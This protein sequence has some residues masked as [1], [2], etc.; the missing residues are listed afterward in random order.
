MVKSVRWE[1]LV[2]RLPKTMII[3]EDEVEGGPLSFGE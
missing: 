2:R 3:K 1:K